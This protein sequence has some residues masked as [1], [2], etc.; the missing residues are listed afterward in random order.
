MPNSQFPLK[1]RAEVAEGTMAF[2]F[3]TSSAPDFTF[4]AGQNADYTLIDPP[5][6]DA[7]GN[8]RSFSFAQSPHHTGEIMIATRMRDTAFKRTLKTMPIGTK[9]SVVGPLGNMVLHEDAG[10][11][12]V[13]L[14]GGIGI[15]P[16]RSM[17]EWATHQKLPH[18]LHL[19][20]SN[21]TK[22]AT[23]FHDDFLHWASANQSFHYRPLITEEEPTDPM[24]QAGR[25]DLEKIQA[26]VPDVQQAIFYMAGPSG[27]VLAMRKMLLDGGVGRD[28][29]K[30]ES[31]TGY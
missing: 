31:F 6:T 14:A 3:D 11:P 29:I 15:T 13:L 30:L 9:I 26:Q 18:H 12:A 23:A 27:F 21:R 28:S 1:K 4:E 10:K 17:V 25:I 16:F 8:K 5:E 24:F 7:E 2:W 20:Y 22:P 19:L